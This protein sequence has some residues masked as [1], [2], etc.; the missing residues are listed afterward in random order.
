MADSDTTAPTVYQLIGYGLTVDETGRRRTWE[1]G[2][3]TAAEW[4]ASH[5]ARE[6]YSIAHDEQLTG[7][8]EQYRLY[9][10]EHALEKLWDIA[11]KDLLDE[12]KSRP[13]LRGWIAR[14]LEP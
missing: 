14:R 13:G 12:R 3:P 1:H 11:R 7:D 2:D 5:M 10:I 4:A 9:L 6:V 8:K